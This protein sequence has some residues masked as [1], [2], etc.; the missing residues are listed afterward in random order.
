MGKASDQEKLLQQTDSLLRLRSYAAAFDLLQQA[1]PSHQQ[2][3]LVLRKVD[4]AWNYYVRSI[5]HQL[6]AFKNLDVSEQLDSLRQAGG[7]YRVV[8]FPADT[9]LKKLLRKHPQDFRLHKALGDYY[10][11]VF[12]KYDGSWLLEEA[13]LIEQI[14]YHLRL[15]VDNGE[16]DAMSYYVLG[17]FALTNGETDEAIT[18]FRQS[19]QRNDQFPTAHYN[20]AYAYME[21][22][23]RSQAIEAAKAALK[24]YHAANYKADAARM[25]AIL[26][27]EEKNYEQ[28]E[29][30]YAISDSLLPDNLNTLTLR[31]SLYLR[32]EKYNGAQK[33]GLNILALNPRDPEVIRQLAVIY[34]QRKQT[35]QLIDL[36]EEGKKRYD[37][38]AAARG[39]LCFFMGRAYSLLDEVDAAR[40]ALKE[41]RRQ[42]ESVYPEEKHPVFK[43]I[44]K[45]LADL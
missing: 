30:F 41:A 7:D 22:K 42:F 31:T 36:L 28:A 8:R 44:E 24:L 14:R 11:D 4:I 45:A 15:A 35:R 10:Y 40:K 33:L 20:L 43:A 18:F 34:V 1:D 16:G 23:Q 3:D 32:Q 26:Y 9:I 17:F 21:L 6:F 38:D 29:R 19:I 39:N 27:E 12:L 2:P 5:M 37:A 13:K 25:V